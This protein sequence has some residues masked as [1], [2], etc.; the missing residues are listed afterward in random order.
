[1]DATWT[2]DDGAVRLFL[3]NCLDVI[4]SIYD[5]AAVVTDPPYGVSHKSGWSSELYGEIAED[6]DE[7]RVAGDSDT[8]ARDAALSAL[9]GIPALVFGS[10]KIPKPNG[11]KALLIW[12][13]TEVAGMGDLSLPWKPNH[14]EIYVIGRGFTGSHRGTS[15]LRHYVPGRISLGRCHPTEKPVSL[16]RELVVACP[17][18]RIIDPFMGSGSTGVACVAEGRPF[19]GIET[20]QKYFDIARNR[21]QEAMG[22]EVKRNGVTQKRMFGQDIN[23]V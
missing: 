2:S 15:I 9:S 7:G 14:E 4:P 21:I 8:M 17:P 6:W 20:E 22:L 18:G 16:M 1:M 5:A 19:T 10:W 3:G 23:G 13:K 11:V 12:D